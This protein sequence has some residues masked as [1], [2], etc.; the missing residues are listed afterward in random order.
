VRFQVYLRPVRHEPDLRV[1]K[2]DVP[3]GRQ[4]RGLM[5]VCRFV[6]RDEP[7]APGP[8]NV[9]AQ[10]HETK[11]LIIIE[12]VGGQGH[13][14]FR[15]RFR[16]QHRRSELFRA[17][18][19]IFPPQVLVGETDIGG[20]VGLGA[21][22]GIRR[23][24]GGLGC[25]YSSVGSRLVSMAGSSAAGTARKNGREQQKNPGTM[26]RISTV[27]RGTSN[28]KHQTAQQAELRLTA[29]TP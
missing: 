11:Y 3:L 7:A 25:T 27:K 9:P 12:G 29:D 22:P 17:G 2:E 24:I 26:N 13:R 14:V 8:S 6:R 1:G 4:I 20:L 16:Q 23:D 18:T 21:G 5:V 19:A 15:A 10:P 28:V